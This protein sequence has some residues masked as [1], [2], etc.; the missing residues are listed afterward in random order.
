MDFQ[1]LKEMV[2]FGF[3]AKQNSGKFQ[4]MI[5]RFGNGFKSSSMRIANN[6]L[7]ITS[8]A[9]IPKNL[10]KNGEP[11]RIYNMALLSYDMLKNLQMSTVQVPMITLCADIKE[12]GSEE[13]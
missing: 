10:A 11:R 5:G 1:K 3:T 2:S 7:V 4:T 9:P 12:D 13:L 6:C 8:K